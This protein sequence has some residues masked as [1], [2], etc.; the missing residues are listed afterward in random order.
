MN[1]LKIEENIAQAKTISTQFYTDPKYFQ[2]SKQ[3]IFENV[4][5][6]IGDTNLVKD[7]GQCYPFTLLDNYIDE[8]LVLTR[9]KEG[10][11]NCLSNVCTHRG[12]IVVNGPCKISK[13]RCRYHGRNFHLDGK[14]LSMPEFAEVEN[15]PTE[16]DNL[17]KLSLFNWG[18]LLF[19]SL[20]NNIPANEFFKP[21]VERLSWLPVD[22]FIYRGDLSREYTVNAHWALYCENYLEGFHIPFVHASLNTVID[23]GNY[24]TELYR[25]SNLQLGIARHDDDTFDLPESSP[26]Y[27]KKVAAYYFWVFPNMMFNFYPWGLSINHIKPVSID[28]SR[29]SF[30]TYV[31]KEDKLNTGAGSGLDR[32]EREDEEVVEAVQRG[33]RSRF[34][35]HGRYSVTREQGTH[36]FHQLLAE[37]MR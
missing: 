28:K 5:H 8:P 16:E 29:V 1:R 15:F 32:V 20:A 14:F 21:M 6:F 12:T 34:Y 17:K 36:H 10:G 27:G 9:D 23:F 2:E 11:L 18:N 7:P 13:L 37:F 24:T 22:E 35:D 26:D 3:R 25:Y 33:V 19:T 31:W 4:W 30:I